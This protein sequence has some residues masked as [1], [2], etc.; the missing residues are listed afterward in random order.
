MTAATMANGT[1]PAPPVTSALGA[2]YPY[3]EGWYPAAAPPDVRT[4]PAIP[5]N[6]F[7]HTSPT[8]AYRPSA[9]TTEI[10]RTSARSRCSS[11]VASD[12]YRTAKNTAAT[13]SASS[14]DTPR[15]SDAAASRSPR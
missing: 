6:S 4:Q 15:T 9:A 10:V 14:A 3:A 13:A 8:T 2:P 1:Q 11:Q 12:V 5:A 7:G